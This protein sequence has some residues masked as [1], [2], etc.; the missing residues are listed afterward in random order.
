MEKEEESNPSEEGTA[1][2]RADFVKKLQ[3][4][5]ANDTKDKKDTK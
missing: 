4:E 3:A 5:T 2:A 1:Q